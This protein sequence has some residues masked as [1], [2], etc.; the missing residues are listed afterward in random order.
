MLAAS[1]KAVS[2]GGCAQI[3]DGGISTSSYVA[4]FCQS[5][6][7]CDI[8]P[9][10]TFS[11]HFCH[12]SSRSTSPLT[13][14]TMRYSSFVFDP[15]STCPIRISARRPLKNTSCWGSSNGADDDAKNVSRWRPSFPRNRKNIAAVAAVVAA[16]AI[17]FPIVSHADVSGITGG[18]TEIASSTSSLVESLAQTGFWQAFSLVFL[19]EIGDKTFFIAGLL[20]AKTSKFVSF[21]GSMA[22]LTVMTI[23]SVGIGQVFHAVPSGLGQGLPIDDIAAVLAFAFFGL[24]TLKDAIEMDPDESVMDEELADAQEAVDG[25]DTSKQETPW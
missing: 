22:A 9:H 21:V 15:Q 18:A 23:L 25:S 5:D 1:I 2:D 24:K 11:L 7:D 10:L 14:G 12:D 3:F 16:V 4:Y 13:M 6:S 19:S 20:A 8:R 17:S